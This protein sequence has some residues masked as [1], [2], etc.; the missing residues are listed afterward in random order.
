M[1]AGSWYPEVYKIGYGLAINTCETCDFI[2]K[3]LLIDTDSSN[4]TG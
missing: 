1:Q 4:L 2:T 3:S